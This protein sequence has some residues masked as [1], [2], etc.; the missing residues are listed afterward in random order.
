MRGDSWAG[1][2]QPTNININNNI[3]KRKVFFKKLRNT[4][5]T[6]LKSI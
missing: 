6:Q 2:R 1:A 3:N 5:S 4:R